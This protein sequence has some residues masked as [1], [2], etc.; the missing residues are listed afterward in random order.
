MDIITVR[1]AAERWGLTERHV[2]GLVRNGRIAG[3]YKIGVS[4]VMPADTQKPIHKK[5][6]QAARKRGI[7]STPQPAIDTP[8][9]FAGMFQKLLGNEDLMFQL[10]SLFP[11][12]IQIF[13]PDG[14]MLFANR[15]FCEDTN[16]GDPDQGVGRY[17]IL[18]DPVTL[19]V[20]GLREAVEA[21]FKGERRT[22]YDVRIPYEDIQTRHEKMDENFTEVK[23]HNVTGFPLWDDQ[24][25]VC[26]IM[27]FTTKAAYT[28][29]KDI[30]KVQEYIE[31]NWLED[32]DRNKIADALHMNRNYFSGFFKQNTGESPQDYYRKV[33][34][35]KLKDTLLDPNLNIAE[36]FAACG[37]DYD[38]N[39]RRYF[40]EIAGMSPSQYRENKF[41]TE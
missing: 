5:K 25:I 24:R 18:K 16:V 30:V 14:N 35:N 7:E 10:L 4:W 34:V 2:T 36:A 11:Y 26:I 22:M 21:V 38:G 41:K 31:Q 12:G 19:D 1:E 23:Y 29:N 27:L 9:A 28:G 15:A 32:F 6:E 13:A 8:D 17:N 33:K 37:V 20:L 39:Y 3:A 40:K